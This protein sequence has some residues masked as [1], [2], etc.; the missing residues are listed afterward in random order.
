MNPYLLATSI[1]LFL[2]IVLCLAVIQH[3]EMKIIRLE[4]RWD[5]RE[6]LERMALELSARSGMSYADAVDGLLRVQNGL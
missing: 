6:R 5:S 3:Q 2:G 4:I 1:V